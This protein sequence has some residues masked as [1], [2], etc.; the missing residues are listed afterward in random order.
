SRRTPTRA[1]PPTATYS[2]IDARLARAPEPEG[3]VRSRRI[4]DGHQREYPG[5]RA[6]GPGAATSQRARE[7]AEAAS[8]R[9]GRCAIAPET[10]RI[11]ACEGH[12]HDRGVRRPVGAAV[13]EVAPVGDPLLH[14]PHHVE[15]APARLAARPRSRVRRVEGVRGARRRAVVG[16]PGV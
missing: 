1:I 8:A 4:E 6:V 2:T 9:S 15:R 16:V 7:V 13:R 10:A 11:I 12:A 5:A 3:G 14:V